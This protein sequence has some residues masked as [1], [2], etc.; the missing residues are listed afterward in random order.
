MAA[1]VLLANANIDS[2]QRISILAAA[3]PS[4][5]NLDMKSNTD[6]FIWSVNYVT[7]AS[8]LR[9]CDRPSSIQTFQHGTVS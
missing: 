3:E 7:I 2:S 8:V 1:L 6:E 9:Q 5:D 4:K